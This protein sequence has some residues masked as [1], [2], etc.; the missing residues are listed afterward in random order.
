MT[1]IQHNQLAPLAEDQFKGFV[2]K[3]IRE[4]DVFI[5][6][7]WIKLGSNTQDQSKNIQDWATY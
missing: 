5:G 3:N 6:Q 1:R 7:I 4:S 2:R